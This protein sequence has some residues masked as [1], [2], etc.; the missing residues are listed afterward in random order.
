MAVELSCPE[1]ASWR[2]LFDGA[3]PPE[4]RERLERHL[5]ACPACQRLLDQ[6]ELG[7][8]PLRQIVGRVGDPAAVPADPTLSHFLERLHQ[9]P[10]TERPAGAAPSDLYFLQPAD[11]PG[12]LG[13]LGRYEVQEV[14]GQGGMGVVLKAFEPA[15]QRVVAIKV[16]APQLAASAGARKRFARE[17][18]AAAA[19]RHEHVVAVHGVHEAEG[20]PYLVMQY[21]AGESLQARL[22]RSGPLDVAAVVCIAQQAASGLAAAHAQGLIHRD[23][24]PANILL[25]ARGLAP[26]AKPQAAVVKITDFGLARTADDAQLTESGVVA[27]TPEYMAPE[28]ARGEAV[29]HRSDLFSLGSVLYTL[30]TGRPPFRGSTALAVLR[31]VS[32]TPAPPVRSVKPDVPAWL[33]ALIARLLAKDPAQ[34]FQSAAEVAALLERYLAHLQQ[35]TAVAVPELPPPPPRPAPGRAGPGNATTTAPGHPRFPRWLLSRSHLLVAVV[36]LASAA[37][38]AAGLTP[39][40]L[41]LANAAPRANPDTQPGEPAP[42]DSDVW[43]VACSPDGKVVAAGAGLWDK[44]G[45]L[46]VWNLATREPLQRFVE[47][48][49]VSSVA[50]SPD[51]KLLAAASWTGHV[52]VY[53]WASGKQLFDFLVLGVARLALSPDGR[54]MATATEDQTVQLWDLT[55]GKLLADLEGDLFRFHCVAFSPDGTQ[56]LAGGGDWKPFG[57]NQVTVWDVASRKQ[58]M[59]LTGHMGAVLAIRYSP[60]GKTIATSSVDSTLRTWDAATGNPLKRFIGHG[61]LVETV[62]FTPD[63]KN[64]VSGSQD[65]TVR[66]W[67]VEEAREIGRLPMPGRVRVLAFAPDGQTL[68]VGGNPK[69]LKLLD[70]TTHE[71]LATLWNGGD[72]QL[73]A[74]DHLPI[75]T[76]PPEGDKRW[77]TAAGL[78]GLGLAFVLSITFAVWLSL[79]RP[80]VTPP[81]PAAPTAPVPISFACSGCGKAL[82]G[83]PELAGKKVKCPQCGKPTAVPEAPTVV[84]PA[85][86]P[87]AR[88]PRGAV[89]AAFAASGLLAVLFLAGL[90]L[91]RDTS[92]PP[93]AVSRLQMLANRVKA[94]RSDTIDARHTRGVA[95]ADLSVLEGLP[96]L[97]NL[98]LDHSQIT[99]AGLKVVARAGG[100]LVSLSVTNTQVTDAGLAEINGLKGLEDLRL[101]KLPITDVGMAQL[102]AFPRL[103]KLSLYQTHVTDEGLA[104]LK[105]CPALE[106]L[107]LDDVAPISDAGL[108][109]LSACRN[110]KYVSVWHTQVTDNGIQELTGAL[111]GLKVNH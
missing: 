42:P 70:A 31:H 65:R 97:R 94:G 83:K 90:G 10:S 40:L 99:D 89:L 60:D 86:A 96:N 34:R 85:A 53:E 78:L 4:E 77:L 106:H 30:C 45:E 6:E 80:A 49:G 17:A 71:E 73:A 76:P 51:G 104:Y 20:L 24:K 11:R 103:K 79:Q 13:T 36:V 55:Q 91:A 1:M 43:C 44:P 109:Y 21:V 87:R 33:E 93:P 22:D 66:F 39:V 101:D 32:D 98:N 105:Q 54:L 111:P 38:V 82:K 88:R 35:P 16:L 108:R 107:S 63:G 69:F 27:G 72:K 5:E 26:A 62:A 102:V 92:K 23:V 25:A 18:K 50:L 58:V 37:V 2:A 19:V 64:L 8:E 47:D 12:L 59:K 7:E 61:S 3:L 68:F 75:A 56:V 41:G 15:L 67:D 57:I 84:A 95:D 81:A 9:T 52:R 74:M 110:L 14:V 46:G 100:N 29:D 28:Q 48:L